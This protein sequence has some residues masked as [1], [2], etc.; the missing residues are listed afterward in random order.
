MEDNEK[1]E[2]AEKF[3]AIIAEKIKEILQLKK[4]NREL[5]KQV[6]SLKAQLRTTNNTLDQYRNYS[7]K[8]YQNDYDYVPYHED[9]HGRE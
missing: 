2:V 1:S 7:R 4:E 5:Q 6:E 8:S 9:D 3:V